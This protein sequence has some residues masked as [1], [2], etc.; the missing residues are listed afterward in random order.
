M[1]PS[2]ID[3]TYR[4]GPMGICRYISLQYCY[5]MHYQTRG[6]LQLAGVKSVVYLLLISSLPHFLIYAEKKS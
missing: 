1:S 2:L 5:R 3:I 6:A 4:I